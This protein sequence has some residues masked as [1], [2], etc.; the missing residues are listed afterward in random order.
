MWRILVILS[1]LAGPQIPTVAFAS[2]KSNVSNITVLPFE[3]NSTDVFSI[4]QIL[5]D[6]RQSFAEND[7]EMAAMRYGVLVKYDPLMEEPIIGLAKSQLALNRPDLAEPLL[8]KTSITTPEIA[9]LLAISTAMNLSFD[10]AEVCLIKSLETH[11]DSRLW[12]LLGNVYSNM[13]QWQ[14]AALA[15][16]SA[17]DAGQRPGLL[18]NNLGLLALHNRDIDLAIQ[19]LESAVSIAPDSI[20][21]DSNRRLA[22]LLNGDYISAL[23]GLTE[24]R[25]AD[26]LTDAS[27]IASKRGD[28]PL[29]E[30]LRVKGI[31]L[32]PKYNPKVQT[33]LQ[34][35]NNKT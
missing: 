22:R 4:F 11:P 15:Y 5:L 20:K 17:E 1:V 28:E 26:L 29:A 16:Q 12:N 31:V 14:K 24:D 32:N 7:F 13:G 19:H 18:S 30:H 25:S 21:F 2:D 9:V 34:R 27:I 6:A 10:E 33:H 35:I 3:E 8:L 23:S